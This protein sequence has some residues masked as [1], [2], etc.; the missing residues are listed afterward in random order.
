MKI[1]LD[2]HLPYA[3]AESFPDDWDIHSTQ[4]MG[5]QG[6]GNGELLQLAAD[7]GSMR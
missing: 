7:E 5:W 4:R 6:K 1:L 2:E 3:L